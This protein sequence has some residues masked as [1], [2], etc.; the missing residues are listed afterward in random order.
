MNT[1]KLLLILGVVVVAFIA[2]LIFG[3]GTVIF[4]VSKNN[5]FNSG[6]VASFS[7]DKYKNPKSIP[8]TVKLRPGR[9][10]VEFKASG[11]QTYIEKVWVLPFSQK[12]VLVEFAEDEIPNRSDIDEI[13]YI[14]LFPKETGDYLITV[15]ITGE[16]GSRKAKE[17]TI[18]VLHRFTSPSDGQLYIN[19]RNQ[20]VNEAKKWLKQNNIPSNIPIIITEKPPAI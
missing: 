14:S 10:T 20:A 11:A 8:V 18:W 5:K 7:H 6:M 19:E 2:I 1:K 9:H 15:E 3:R 17:I 13:P 12:T 4:E 16:V